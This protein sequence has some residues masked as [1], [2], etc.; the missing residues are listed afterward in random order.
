MSKSSPISYSL[1]RF[2]VDEFYD[3]QISQL[4]AGS[5]VLD[6]GGHKFTKRGQFDIENYNLH[7]VYVN[8][9]LAKGTDIQADAARLPFTKGQFDAVICAELLEHMPDPTA[10][11]EQI[12]AVLQPMG[13]IFASAPF[14]YRI[15]ADPNDYGRY[16]D[17]YWQQALGQFGFENIQ[18]VKQ[19]FFYSV[20]IDFL[21]Q[22]GNYLHIP[23]PFGQVLRWMIGA[24]LNP[25]Q[26]WAL[27]HERKNK[28]KEN[29][30]ITS[31]TTGFGIS[32]SKSAYISPN[33]A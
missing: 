6:L 32:A 12:H 30:F 24:I 19:G 20:I 2:F 33:K 21:R 29:G 4:E 5:L 23:R 25:L 26:S 17:H 7:V 14:L 18:I 9:S 15:H 13:K 11:L 28:V 8:L 27:R 16:T 22:Y 10:V 31:F 3:Q 1:R